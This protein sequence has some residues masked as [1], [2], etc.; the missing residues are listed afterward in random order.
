MATSTIRNT[1]QTRRWTLED[2]SPSPDT[3]YYELL[4][5]W[6]QT[7][8]V[9]PRKVESLHE[10]SDGDVLWM[11]DLDERQYMTASMGLKKVYL[12]QNGCALMERDWLLTEDDFQS[13]R[14]RYG[15]TV[16]ARRTNGP[17]VSALKKIEWAKQYLGIK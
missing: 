8:L 15:F 14:K 10:V 2:G 1:D 4:R 17:P 12:C 9:E 3:N 7:E 13:L 11:Y 5:N 16:V 6:V